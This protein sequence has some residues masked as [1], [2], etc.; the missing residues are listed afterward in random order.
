MPEIN[1]ADE[2]SIPYSAAL[3]AAAYY[4]DNVELYKGTKV[5]IPYIE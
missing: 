1:G 5:W 2:G 4:G 3:F